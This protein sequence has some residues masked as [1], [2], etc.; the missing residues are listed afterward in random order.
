MN[1]KHRYGIGLALQVFEYLQRCHSIDF[2]HYGYCGVG[3]A[4]DGERIHD[5]HFDEW[6][7]WRGGKQ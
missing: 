1:E 4:V 3:F 7:T 6:L 5:T 2:N